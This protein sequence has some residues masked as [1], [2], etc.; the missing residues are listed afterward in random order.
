MTLICITEVPNPNLGQRSAFSNRLFPLSFHAHITLI[1]VTGS[2]IHEYPLFVAH[3]NSHIIHSISHNS[4]VD[5]NN[6][7][8]AKLTVSYISVI[9]PLSWI[10]N[11][12]TAFTRTFL[13]LDLQSEES[14]C[15]HNPC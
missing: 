13:W 1:S 3:H 8:V 2:I 10:L 7:N 6:S 5:I 12:I 11:S 15:F 4:A 14:A 9:S